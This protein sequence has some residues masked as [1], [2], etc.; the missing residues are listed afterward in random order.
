MSR[1]IIRI[2][3]VAAQAGFAIGIWLAC[4][5]QPTAA[6]SGATMT[7]ECRRVAKTPDIV[8][9]TA[10][11]ALESMRLTVAKEGRAGLAIPARIDV[12]LVEAALQGEVDSAGCRHSSGRAITPDTLLRLPI[13]RPV[14]ASG[15]LDKW[16]VRGICT[17]AASQ[18]RCSATA[19]ELMLAKDESA[20]FSPTLQY[21]LG[22]EVAHIVLGHPLAPLASTAQSASTSSRLG[23]AL[24]VCTNEADAI[25]QE[26]AADDLA[27]KLLKQEL[28]AR[29]IKDDRTFDG[30]KAV[31]SWLLW[32][33]GQSGRLQR[34]K[35]F[36]QYIR[37]GTDGWQL[38]MHYGSHPRVVGRLARIAASSGVMGAGSIARSARLDD[39]WAEDF[40]RQARAFEARQITCDEA[41][42]AGGLTARRTEIDGSPAISYTTEASG[43]QAA[44][45]D[46][47]T[48]PSDLLNELCTE[49]P[50]TCPALTRA[51]VVC[52][53]GQMSAC[54]DLAKG[55]ADRLRLF[56]KAAVVYGY[57]CYRKDPGACMQLGNL[58]KIGA[59]SGTP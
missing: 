51:L 5:L 32:T 22:H 6:Q 9:E 18:I 26:T 39:L 37:S 56:D 34:G 43:G 50:K 45:Q 23:A 4:A 7:P 31:Y 44:M 24:D 42:H 14:K 47:K 55:L 25:A 35:T 28:S 41:D 54:N 8:S 15:E 49:Y 53:L 57:A 58:H 33:A 38:P 36:C 12:M 30:F 59:L 13:E 52:G 16:S 17:A 11:R 46:Q 48:L 10:Q 19:I 1:P 21:V 29:A 3:L 40:C 20:S 2:Q 27:L